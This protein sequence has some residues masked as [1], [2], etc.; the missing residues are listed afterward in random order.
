MSD[1]PKP[2]FPT[3]LK[4]VHQQLCRDMGWLHA[5]L[6]VFRDLYLNPSN[7]QVAREVARDFCV[8]VEGALL[9]SVI[10]ALSRLTEN[11]TTGGRPN[12]SLRYLLDLLSTYPGVQNLSGRCE[13]QIQAT[14]A[15]LDPLRGFRNQVI[16]HRD[17][18]TALTMEPAELPIP[19]A[20]ISE[21]CSD[22]GE[23]LNDIDDHFTGAVT[24]FENPIEVGGVDNLIHYLRRGIQSFD[25]DE[26]ARFGSK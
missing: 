17:R 9:T 24:P 15:T 16:A 13:T 26:Q 5:Q 10:M 4:N 6:K 12:L 22:L 25:D 21:L 3:E 11:A 18:A 1:E 8:V 2:G 23:L 19:I 14:V 20:T 7:L